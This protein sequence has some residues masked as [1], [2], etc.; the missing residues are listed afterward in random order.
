MNESQE[1]FCQRLMAADPVT[2]QF[3]EKYDKELQMLFTD[4]KI[5]DLE[6]MPKRKLM[7]QTIICLVVG[8]AAAVLAAL[9]PEPYLQTPMNRGLLGVIAV[10]TLAMAAYLIGLLQ[11][12]KV[13]LGTYNAPLENLGWTMNVIIFGI[14]AFNSFTGG[15]GG[16]QLLGFGVGILVFV[17]VNKIVQDMRRAELR[18]QEKLLKLECQFAELTEKL[19]MGPDSSN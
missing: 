4:Q 17:G 3:K 8:V 19:Q 7:A 11:R 1:K 18:T 12:G 15:P 2:P 6:G 14:F 13:N 16:L 10:F 5:K 9:G